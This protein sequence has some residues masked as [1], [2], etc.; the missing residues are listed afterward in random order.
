MKLKNKLFISALMIGLG[1]TGY[2]KTGDKVEIAEP[3]EAKVVTDGLEAPWAMSVAPDG[4]LWITE[5]E[6]KHIAKI[7]PETGEYKRLY[8]VENA[9]VGPQHEGVLGLAFGPN[10]M[11]KKIMRKMKYILPI[12]IKTKKEQNLQEYHV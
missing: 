6:G 11:S 12:R 5:R 10:F 3:F 7:N 1:I 4:N 8:T 2:A 9:F